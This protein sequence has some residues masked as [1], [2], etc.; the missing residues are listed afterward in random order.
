[1]QTSETGSSWGVVGS[2]DASDEDA[3]PVIALSRGDRRQIALNGL[4]AIALLATLYVASALLIPIVVAVLLSIL[5]NP[6]VVVARRVGMPE[7]LSSVLVV[8][9]VV[10]LCFATA[11]GI[12]GAAQEW[13]TRIPTNF[14]KIEAKLKPLKKPIE[15]LKK[16]TEKIEDATTVNDRKP[17]KVTVE[18][19]GVAERFLTGT[20]EVM[21]SLGM[22]ILL[23]YFLL[24]SGD[25][26]LRKVVTITPAFEDKKRAV[27]ITR[28]IQTE[29]SFY[30]RSLTL[31]NVTLGV[32]N[33]AV[34]WA[35]GLPNPLLWGVVVAVLSFAPYAGSA[36]IAGLLS[37]VGMLTFEEWL[38]ALT[39][40]GVYLFSM[41]IAGNVVIPYVLGRRLTL[42]PLAIFVAIIFWGWMWGVIGALVAV[43]LLASFKIICERIEPLQP[44]AEFLTP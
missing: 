4:F 30:L 13:F 42:S 10:L 31:M 5:L 23:V 24:A 43:P 6:I 41:F 26:F 9:A 28:N 12:A 32:I 15:Q 34:C 17:L 18:R 16:A 20:P 44:I 14:F 33:G 19:P 3:G 21:A 35:V 22:I 11:A 1:M 29:I 36:V 40:T 27:E 2:T 25:T 8:L 7:Q 39:P 38:P 37:F